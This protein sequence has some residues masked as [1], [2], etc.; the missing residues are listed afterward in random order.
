MKDMLL[1]MGVKEH[2]KGFKPD[3]NTN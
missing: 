1:S 2:L 3:C